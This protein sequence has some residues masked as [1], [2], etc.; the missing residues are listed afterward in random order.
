[1]LSY[2]VRGTDAYGPSPNSGQDQRSIPAV[3]RE[4]ILGRR[5]GRKRSGVCR[6]LT[7]AGAAKPGVVDRPRE[8]HSPAPRMS[9]GTN[10]GHFDEPEQ[11]ATMRILCRWNRSS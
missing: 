8:A 3:P 4:M 5:L 7:A 10:F 6:R 2:S 1:M 11:K 9:F